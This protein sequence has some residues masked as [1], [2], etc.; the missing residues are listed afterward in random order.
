[1]NSDR[2]GESPEALRLKKTCDDVPAPN[3]LNLKTD[4]MQAL[5]SSNFEASTGG[6]GDFFAS[7]GL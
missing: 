3:R 5:C 4:Y 1:M 7:L 2:P 6:H